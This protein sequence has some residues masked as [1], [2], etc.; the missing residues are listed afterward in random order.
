MALAPA[1][2]CGFAG[3][4]FEETILAWDEGARWAFRVDSAQAPV[5]VRFRRGLP[6][7]ARR[8]R[9]HP[10]ALGV[11]PKRGRSQR[12][13]TIT[14]TAAAPARRTASTADWALAPRLQVRV[15]VAVAVAR[16]GTPVG[17]ER[18]GDR[19]SSILSAQ[20]YWRRTPVSPAHHARCG[21]GEYRAYVDSS[22]A[23]SSIF[24]CNSRSRG[25]GSMPNSLLSSARSC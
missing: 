25:P 11:W 6:F 1:A 10:A 24:C 15:R 17:V 8:Q 2:Q 20:S 18:R 21:S 3:V 4:K 16:Q 12:P 5:F 13:T 19:H 14:L 9:R 7:R 22:G 23:A